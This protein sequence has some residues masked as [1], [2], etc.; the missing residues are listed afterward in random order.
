M[1]ITKEQILPFL[2]KNM[3]IALILIMVI[4]SFAVMD[5]NDKTVDKLVMDTS[6]TFISVSIIKGTADMI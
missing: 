1:K 3:I 6:T 2:K 5:K 4:L